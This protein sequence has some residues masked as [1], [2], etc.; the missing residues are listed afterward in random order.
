MAYQSNPIFEYF[1]DSDKITCR[2]VGAVT[3]KTLVK[4]VAGG[5]DQVPAVSTA[6]ASDVAYGVAGWD[7]ADGEKVTI[8]RRGVLSVT[9]SAALTAGTR[10]QPAANGR[11]AALTTGTPVGQ[12]HAD[13]ASGAD[14]A[15]AVNF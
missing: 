1:T 9:A 11:V 10:V 2:A 15:V 6:G 3:G 8:Y 5:A 14:A 12:V 7:V 13:A 4:L